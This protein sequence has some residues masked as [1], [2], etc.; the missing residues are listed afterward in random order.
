MSWLRGWFVR[1]TCSEEQIFA[2][3]GHSE[4]AEVFIVSQIKRKIY[5]SEQLKIMR[6]AQK[7]CQSNWSGKTNLFKIRTF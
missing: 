4:D 3:Y 1:T 2:K 7:D 5:E 6:Q